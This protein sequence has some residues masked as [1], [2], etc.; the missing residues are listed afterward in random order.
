MGRNK[1]STPYIQ[2]CLD[3]TLTSVSATLFHKQLD[4]RKH[5][6]FVCFSVHTFLVE[7]CNQK[8]L[9]DLEI[10]LHCHHQK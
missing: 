10:I 4:K 2:G 7:K 3:H 6:C 8:L 5:I 9:H 1:K